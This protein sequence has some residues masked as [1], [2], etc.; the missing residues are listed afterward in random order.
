MITKNNKMFS[1]QKD[2]ELWK[3]P[4]QVTNKKLPI[5]DKKL[6]KQVTIVTHTGNK[7]LPI[8]ADTKEKKD[9]YTKDT[10][11]K[12]NINKIII[13][14]KEI[15]KLFLSTCISLP[16]IIELTDKRKTAIKGR[17]LKYKDMG[18]FR[19]L[20]KK[21]EAS[22]FLSGRNGKW[23]ACNFDW[24]LNENN[25]IKVLEENYKNKK[26]TDWKLK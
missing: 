4:T 12:R 2:Y 11:Q 22:D 16:K 5:Q 19:E 1:I 21:A 8:Q 17:Y 9:T 24:L 14:Y 25:M 26:N 3:L 6:P 10:I 20:F 7:K 15:E 13:P 18:V 23:T